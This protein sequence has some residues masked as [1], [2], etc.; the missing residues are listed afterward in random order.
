MQNHVYIAADIFQQDFF[1]IK[2]LK[3]GQNLFQLLHHK[4]APM[5]C[6]L[7]RGHVQ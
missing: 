3:L 7:L 2:V 4:F 6:N 1:D 5:L